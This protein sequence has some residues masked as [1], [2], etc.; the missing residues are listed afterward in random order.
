MWKEDQRTRKKEVLSGH[1]ITSS[2]VSHCTT[3]R[4]EVPAVTRD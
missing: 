3:V 2:H 1:L 4:L